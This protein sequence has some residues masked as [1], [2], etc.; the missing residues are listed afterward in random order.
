MIVARSFGQSVGCRSVGLY[1]FLT[2]VVYFS[3]F[4][5]FEVDRQHD[6]SPLKNG[7]D[8]PK[9]SAVS[10]KLD[11]FKLHQSYLKAAGATFDDR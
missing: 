10:C 7:P 1:P 6:F 9:A 11:T 4:A 3:K 5:V 8:T 2:F